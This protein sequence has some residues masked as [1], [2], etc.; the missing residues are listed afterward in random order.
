MPEASAGGSGEAWIFGNN[1]QSLRRLPHPGHVRKARGKAFR[2]R[3]GAG[4][5]TTRCVGCGPIL[6]MASG[7]RPMS[8]TGQGGSRPRGGP[9]PA[10]ARFLGHDGAGGGG[11]MRRRHAPDLATVQHAPVR[12]KAGPTCAS[13]SPVLRPVT[14]WFVYLLRCRDGSLY[15]G[16]TNDLPRRLKAHAAGRASKYTRSRL[17]VRLVS[18]EQ[19]P[20]KSAALKREAAIKRLP[21]RQKLLLVKKAWHDRAGGVKSNGSR[22]TP[23]LGC[24][25]ARQNRPRIGAQNRPPCGG[26]AVAFPAS[27]G[28]RRCRSGGRS[29]RASG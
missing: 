8:S 17:P 2:S 9:C 20:T 28:A 24:H 22:N 14:S 12:R 29:L 25:S 18:T 7:E 6:S 3:C 26:G 19:Q 13:P 5:S 1:P 16:I 15:T 23:P 11:G 27:W 4:V 21:R 10:R